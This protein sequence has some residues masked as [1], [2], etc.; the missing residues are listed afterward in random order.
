V[1]VERIADMMAPHPTLSEA[2][3]GAAQVALGRAIDLPNRARTDEADPT[4]DARLQAQ[5]PRNLRYSSEHIWG[6]FGD[7]RVQIGIT[8]YAQHALGDVTFVQLP[9]VGSAMTVGAVLGQ[10]QSLKSDS[11]LYS[12]VAGTVA[13]VNASLSGAPELVNDDP[14]GKGWICEMESTATESDDGLMDAEA[15]EDLITRH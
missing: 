14:Y 6:R 2:I 15:Y 12:P 4:G 3:K 11:E 5:V 9:E 1:S 8:D 7:G 10:V 13:V